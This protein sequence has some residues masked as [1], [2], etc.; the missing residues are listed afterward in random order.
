MCAV[1]LCEDELLCVCACRLRPYNITSTLL[2]QAGHV[3][4]DD[5][6]MVNGAPIGCIRVSFGYM[7]TLDDALKFMEFVKQCLVDNSCSVKSQETKDQ[8]VMG[9]EQIQSMKQCALAEVDDTLKREVKDLKKQIADLTESVKLLAGKVRK[10]LTLI[11]ELKFPNDFFV[12]P[13]ICTASRRECF[14]TSGLYYVQFSDSSIIIFA[15]KCS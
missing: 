10:M 9:Q 1:F 4:G 5:M 2:L 13:W 11:C 3:C 12:L 8:C 6:D 7:S 14:P 15:L